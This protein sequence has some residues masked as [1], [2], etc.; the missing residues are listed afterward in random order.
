MK[1]EIYVQARM[2]STRLPGKVMKTI[3]GKPLLGYLIER[4]KQV[5]E[6]DAFAILT[7]THPDDDVIES[8]CQQEGI[9]CYRGPEKDVLTRYYQVAQERKPDAIV[10]ITS[11][12]P[13]IDPDIVDQVIQI[14]RK[15]YPHEDYVSNS[16]ERTYPRGLDTEI[17]S[18][19]A[20]EEAFKKAI[21]EEEREHVTLY[22]YQHPEQFRLKNVSNSTF[23]SEYRWTVDT[24]EDFTLIRLILENLY[25]IHPSFRLKDVLCL[26]QKNPEWNKINAHIQQKQIRL[27]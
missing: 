25:P 26:L 3:L 27:T 17:F 11:D 18:F 16:L 12:C 5:K 21:K 1:V 20:L 9:L 7:T 15:D 8:Y 2:R 10:R 19:Q 23:L 14:Y 24:S 13:L 6:A 4:L 22:I